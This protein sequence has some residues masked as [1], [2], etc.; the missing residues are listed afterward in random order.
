LLPKI[1][2]RYYVRNSEEKKK[3]KICGLVGIRI[4]IWAIGFHESELIKAWHATGFSAFKH[5]RSHELEPL[6]QDQRMKF[7]MH[8]LSLDY[9]AKNDS[10]IFIQRLILSH[11]VNSINSRPQKIWVL[12][13]HLRINIVPLSLSFSKIF[14]QT[15]L[16]ELQLKTL[17]TV[18]LL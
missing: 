8:I 17:D 1:K 13:T 3:D 11:C 7:R 5:S 2:F 15:L 6:D 10:S 4:R 16:F 12:G 18:I 9:E 14:S